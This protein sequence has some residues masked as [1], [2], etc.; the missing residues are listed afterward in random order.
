M[1][2]CHK[3]Y[4]SEGSLNQHMKLKHPEYYQ[5]QVLCGNLQSGP[6][7]ISSTMNRHRQGY[8]TGADQGMD[9]EDDQ[10]GDQYGDEKD[11]GDDGE[12]TS[13]PAPGDGTVQDE[14]DGKTLSKRD[15]DDDELDEVEEEDGDEEGEEEGQPLPSGSQ[16]YADNSYRRQMEEEPRY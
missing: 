12:G 1:A 16:S 10:M 2:D 6:G 9:P 5:Q 13:N 15:P 14:D 8:H 4:G 11:L 7:R 3:S